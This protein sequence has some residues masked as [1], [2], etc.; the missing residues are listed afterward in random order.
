LIDMH[1]HI[2]PGI[3]DGAKDLA[4]ALEMLRIAEANGTAAIV[5]TPHVIEGKWL[6]SWE[7]ITK[8]CC[9]LQAAAH[10]N[11]LEVTLYPGAE[12]AVNLDILELLKKPGQYCING[13]CYILVEL[14]AAEIPNYTEDFFFTLQA[15]GIT[16]V[17]AHP[18]RHPRIIKKPEILLD[19]IKKGILVQ[20]NAPSLMGGMG[21]AVM[22]S[23]EC[24]LN[25]NMVHVIGS[26]AHSTRTRNPNLSQASGKITVMA[27][28]ATYR[29]LFCDNTKAIITSS[30]FTPREPAFSHRYQDKQEEQSVF[31]KLKRLFL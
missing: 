17:L 11:G 6:P 1:C 4:T 26:D 30:E 13:G 12:V 3:D 9:D 2:L 5:A 18:E 28:D 22:H 7:E 16:P 27:G 25:S 19:W 31:Q 15:R 10:E 21:E 20:L 23:A 29:E 14:P 8:S 24:L